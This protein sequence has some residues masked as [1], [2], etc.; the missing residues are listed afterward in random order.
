MSK[1]INEQ[2]KKIYESQT[3]CR[4]PN[5]PFAKNTQSY[6]QTQAFIFIFLNVMNAENKLGAL[7]Q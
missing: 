5:F 7:D 3:K 6:M 2:K 1:Q 4:F